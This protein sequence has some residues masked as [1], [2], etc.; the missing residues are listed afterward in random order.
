MLLRGGRYYVRRHIPCDVQSIIGRAEVWRSLKTDSLQLALRRLPRALS[1]IEAEF[2]H[3]RLQAGIP[4]DTTL[5]NSSGHAPANSPS[6]NPEVPL[7]TTSSLPSKEN[8]LRDVYNR[9]IDDPTHAWSTSTRQAYETTRTV[10]LEMLGGQTAIS[11]LTRADLRQ[12]IDVLRFLPR[13]SSKLFPKLSLREAAEL[14]RSNPAIKRISTANVNV[15]LGNLSTFLNWCVSEEVIARNPARGLRLPDEVAKRDKRHPFSRDQLRRIFRAPLYTGCADGGRGYALPGRDCPRNARYWIPLI[16]L[17]TGMRLNEICQLDALDIRLIDDVACIVATTHSL[18]G[19]T[20]KSLKTRGSERIIPIHPTLLD[21][22]L[23]QYAEKVHRSGEPKLFHEIDPGAEGVRAVAFSKWFTQFLT[24]AGARK[25]RTSFHSLRHNFRD[26]LRSCR[27]D[28]DI[29]MALGGWV[30]GAA[31][32]NAASEN[33][34]HGF[35]VETL[36]DAVFRLRFSEVDLSH[37][38]S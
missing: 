23:P 38:R 29:A 27:I 8:S 10:A 31:K 18:V 25:E 3:L 37:L 22:G 34:G 4:V 5:V 19:S 36:R 9:Y 28:H 15:Y 20:D 33:Y 21:L 30:G 35:K 16:G 26:E 32:T 7:T 12:L 17:H 14:A 6:T 1:E 13:N 24:S 11:D 2:E